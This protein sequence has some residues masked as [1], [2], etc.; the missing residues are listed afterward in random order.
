[1]PP[2]PASSG[3]SRQGRRASLRQYRKKRDLARS[4]EP[5]ADS[6]GRGGRGRKPRFVVQQHSASTDHYDFRLEAE[7]VLKSW[8]LPKG[9][10][11]NPR[12]KRL[13]PCTT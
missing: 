10:S 8:A 12:D 6:S 13:A 1:M 5:R 4:G 3:D 7:R 9:P 11:V 2:K